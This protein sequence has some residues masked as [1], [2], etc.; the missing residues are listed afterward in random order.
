MKLFFDSSVIVDIDR[1][2]EQTVSLMKKLTEGG[3]SFLISS[4]TV[5]E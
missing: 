2:R 4:V 1:G 5:A 3:N